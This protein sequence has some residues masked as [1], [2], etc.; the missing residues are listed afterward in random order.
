MSMTHLARGW[1]SCVACWLC[2]ALAVAGASFALD[3]RLKVRGVIVDRS[4][5]SD[6]DIRLVLNRLAE[7]PSVWSSA[8]ADEGSGV[9]VSGGNF[10]TLLP[11]PGFWSLRID[12]PGHVSIEMA[13]APLFDDLMLA[14]ARI[15]TSK[16]WRIHVRDTSGQPLEGVGVLWGVEGEPRASHWSPADSLTR[17]DASGLARI[18]S[19]PGLWRTILYAEGYEELIVEPH[20]ESSE[21]VLEEAQSME[22]RIRGQG[23]EPVEGVEVLAGEGRWPMGST[24]AD[25]R[26]GVGRLTETTNRFWWTDRHGKSGYFTISPPFGEGVLDVVLTPEC[27][28]GRVLDLDTRQPIPSAAF[29]QFEKPRIHSLADSEGSISTCLPRWG[30]EQ[31]VVEVGAPGY[32]SQKRTLSAAVK[33]RGD[34]GAIFLEAYS[35][36]TGRVVDASTLDPIE[37]ASMF[38]FENPRPA[39][40]DGVGVPTDTVR[41][42]SDANGA[43]RIDDWSRNAESYLGVW[44][45]G[46]KPHIM[47]VGS[48]GDLSAVELQPA[49]RLEGRVVDREG[50]PIGGA[51][52]LL[53]GDRSMPLFT[54]AEG[55]FGTEDSKRLQETVVH[56]WAEGF[57]WAEV[58][59][60]DPASPVTVTLERG[61]TLEGRVV[62]DAREPVLDA[63]VRLLSPG[64]DH[65]ILG[66]NLVASTDADGRFLLQ[67]L[68]LGSL[69]LETTHSQYRRH[70]VE[71]VQEGNSRGLFIR[72]EEPAGV[73]VEGRLNAPAGIERE[74]LALRLSPV[75]GGSVPVDTIS[76]DGRFR[77]AVVP[78]GRYRFDLDVPGFY[79]E[80]P[81]LVVGDTPLSGLEIR[82][83]EGG[84][85]RGRLQGLDSTQ[86]PRVRLWAQGMIRRPGTVDPVTGTYEVQGLSP[87]LWRVAAEVGRAGPAAAAVVE[88]A[89]AGHGVIQDLDF[90]P[91]RRVEGSVVSRGVPVTAWVVVKDG[92]GRSMARAR[93]DSLGLFVLDVPRE[94]VFRLEVEMSSGVGNSVVYSQALDLSADKTVDI[95]LRFE[96]LSGRVLDARTREPVAGARLVLG[97]QWPTGT[98]LPLR[99]TFSADDGSFVFPRVPEGRWRL[100]VEAEGFG[101]YGRE[102]IAADQGRAF[103]VLLQPANA[104]ELLVRLPDG[105]YP[106]AVDLAVLDPQ[107]FLLR[108]D[109]LETRMGGAVE[110]LGLPPGAWQIVMRA[111]GGFVSPLMDIEI[112][113]GQPLEATLMLGGS[114]EVIAPEFMGH[115]RASILTLRD[116]AGR[117]MPWTDSL[118]F[119]T[120]RVTVSS[121][122]PGVWTLEI[123][124]VHGDRIVRDVHIEASSHQRWILDPS[125][126]Q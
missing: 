17:T 22:L 97:G 109:R 54:D 53:G 6:E 93:S 47:A 50:Q 113:L 32:I 83:R 33:E 38:L 106:A 125:A 26:I 95:D 117:S 96:E 84:V 37:G 51:W 112:P 7:V 100:E 25:G 87:G 34:W 124:A 120:G 18:Y 40:T 42:I 114:L 10:E 110:L 122:T 72:L 28:R 29:W 123:T 92:A 23:G 67:G 66:L 24:D 13:M 73:F 5:D 121:L 64:P 9:R 14:P 91:G 103:E 31:L 71:H 82:L 30:G 27:I 89:G 4:G 60:T 94:G 77:L 108:R 19:G 16:P 102:V 80:A 69:V 3:P 62:T 126:P 74:G 12:K 104:V 49:R 115:P 43:F 85:V 44:R 20:I 98:V 2:V 101:G 21:V 36:I 48:A 41:A 81:D 39:V 57:L 58:E 119:D 76:A 65:P 61:T 86:T 88:I 56:A 116:S 59:I 8:L 107:G 52:V 90:G 46:F 79:I 78:P 111:S 70:V 99:R 1:I 45:S 105:S 68:P 63:S 35:I 15:S 11:E 75:A 118:H 55:L